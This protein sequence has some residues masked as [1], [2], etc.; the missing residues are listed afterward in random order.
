MEEDE[1]N[2]VRFNKLFESSIIIPFRYLSFFSESAYVSILYEFISVKVIESTKVH[3]KIELS[4]LNYKWI[5]SRS[6]VKIYELEK[7]EHLKNKIYRIQDNLVD[8]KTDKNKCIENVLK[9]IL[10]ASKY[11]DNSEIL[12][13]FNLSKLSFIGR[14]NFEGFFSLREQYFSPKV[15]CCFKKSKHYSKQST[16]YVVC[17]EGYLVFIKNFEDQKIDKIILYDKY[18]KV[19]KG[20]SLMSYSLKISNSEKCFVLSTKNKEEY[21]EFYDLLNKILMESCNTA[22]HRF[23]SFSPVRKNCDFIY[24]IDGKYYF[25][26]LYNRIKKSKNQIFMAGWWISPDIYLKRKLF[27]GKL[28]KKY[29]ID[30][31]LKERAKN[32]VKIYILLYNEYQYALPIN[33]E[34]TEKKLGGLHKNIFI[35]RHP[36][37]NFFDINYWSHHEKIVIVDQEIGFLGGIDIC[38]GRFDTYKH[39]IFEDKKASKQPLKEISFRKHANSNQIK[40]LENILEKPE[41][42]YEIYFGK[43]KQALSKKDEDY[44]SKWPGLDYSNPLKM[45]FRSVGQIKKS[46]IDKTKIPRMPWHDIH[47]KIEGDIV[48]DLSRHFIERWNKARETEK[49]PEN[50]DILLLNDFKPSEGNE[51]NSI[52]VQI[53]RSA[54]FWSLN[55]PTEHSIQNAYLELI[56]RSENYLYF[57]NQFF[58]TNCSENILEYPVNQIGNAIVNKIQQ[59]FKEKKQYKVYIVIPSLPAFEAN[60]TSKKD[61]SIK[62]VMHLQYKSISNGENSMYHVLKRKGINSEDYILFLSLRKGYIDDIKAAYEQIYVH[63]KIVIADGKLGIIGSANLNDR[64]MLGNRDSEIAMIVEDEGNGKIKN[65]MKD[66]LIEHLGLYSDSALQDNN[67]TFFKTFFDKNL[68]DLGNIDF[69]NTLK[70]RAT[71]NTKIFREIFRSIP[72]NDVKT[73]RDYRNFI[74]MASLNTIG[75]KDRHVLFKAFKRI[76]GHFILFSD[77]FL[78]EE[79]EI[80]KIF[81]LQQFLP[82]KIYY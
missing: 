18:F 69:F 57:E 33:S 14:K 48:Y 76:R 56:K 12:I 32:G 60:F 28:D 65:M 26:E 20:T 75:I 31:I 39:E 40:N 37:I 55:I 74:K 11:I 53:L 23:N 77:K 50:F 29:R 30:T 61:S 16:C 25:E 47:S 3:F 78:E 58:I 2:I 81:D 36:K 52:E 68:L 79:E 21:N 17:K 46:L 5:I 72:D 73:A 71:I 35:I 15:V 42:D 24:Y 49:N 9:S 45:D 59:A 38:L 51:S 27:E 80:F 7:L 6:L 19:E 70:S 62:Q 67:D 82:S 54:G 22:T 10:L 66:L 8:F 34:Y 4:Y 41:K 63:S 43:D 64:S 44:S 1:D 13:F